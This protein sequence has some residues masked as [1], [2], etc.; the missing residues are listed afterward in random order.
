MSLIPMPH[1]FIGV[2]RPMREAAQVQPAQSPETRPLPA[3]TR[4]RMQVSRPQWSRAAT[5]IWIAVSVLAAAAQ[6]DVRV[7]CATTV[8]F[9]LMKP[10]KEKIEQLTGVALKIVPSSTS[11]GLL[12]LAQGKADIA[13][14]AEPVEAAAA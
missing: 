1:A 6:A 9:G 7:H 12:D 14:L 4:W 13:M 2:R 3:G 10:Q 8:H 5:T 11:H